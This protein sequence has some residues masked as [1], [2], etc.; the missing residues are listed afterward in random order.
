MLLRQG[1]ARNHDIDRQL[2]CILAAI[3]GAL[4][5][6]AFHAVGYFSANM[7]GNVS[8]L[9]DKAALGQW[10]G[11]TF[12]LTIVVM[13]VLGGTTSTLLIN[14]GR[15]RTIRS[16]YAIAILAEAILMT[17]LGLAE[18]SIPSIERGPVLI[19]GLSFL[20]GMQ[21]AVVTRISDARV[22]ATHVSGMSTDIGIEFGMLLDIIRGREPDA[23]LAPYSARLRLHVQTVLSF[24]TGGVAGIIVYRAIGTRLL[25]AV[26]LLLF[27]M[28]ITAI[29]RARMQVCQL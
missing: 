13:F 8:S 19:L 4:N 10:W 14:A 12:Y 29:V 2:A 5:T 7:T 15:R 20:M 1:E 9:S 17:V 22:R 3:A 23:E 24:L 26:A 11:S 6:A 21:N 18:W 25:F 16:I 28:A 27:A